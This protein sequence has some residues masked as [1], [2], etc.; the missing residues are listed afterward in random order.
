MYV[1]KNWRGNDNIKTNRASAQAWLGHGPT[2]RPFSLF[3]FSLLVYTC[4]SY[5]FKYRYPMEITMKKICHL[6]W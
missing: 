2:E 6:S 1:Y 4:T 3:Y 5:D